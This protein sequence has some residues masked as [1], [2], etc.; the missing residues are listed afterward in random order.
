[1][2]N[3]VPSCIPG[4][5]SKE[6]FQQCRLTRTET[7]GS[8]HLLFV[9]HH[10]R[11]A[12]PTSAGAHPTSA[13]GGPARRCSPT[14][15]PDGGP[16]RRSSPLLWAAAARAGELT[17]TAGRQRGSHRKESSSPSSPVWPSGSRLDTPPLG[18]VDREHRPSSR[19]AR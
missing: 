15:P 8:P 9:H 16:T 18:R 11:G 10:H 1:V 13:G 4:N 14:T 6:R 12:H 7:G 3:R 19:R 2:Q 17:C 5:G